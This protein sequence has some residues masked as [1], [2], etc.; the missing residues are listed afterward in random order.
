MLMWSKMCTV[1]T[2]RSEWSSEVCG[3][4][5]SG[6]RRLP[7]AKLWS[8]QT[9][10]KLTQTTP[11]NLWHTLTPPSTTSYSQTSHTLTRALLIMSNLS[12]FWLKSHIRSFHHRFMPSRFCWWSFSDIPRARFPAFLNAQLCPVVFY[13]GLTRKVSKIPSSSWRQ[14]GA[15]CK[16]WSP[17]TDNTNCTH[18]LLTTCS[19][20]HGFPS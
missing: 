11:H 16:I 7:V 17:Y 5:R 12:T 1:R 4:W 2:L 14:S 9:S 3:W 10:Y 19:S 18:R 15:N 8:L 6:R 20:Y 13:D